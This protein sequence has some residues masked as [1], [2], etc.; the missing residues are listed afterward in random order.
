MML[1]W[2]VILEIKE[3]ILYFYF[4]CLGG[5]KI[6][7]KEKCPYSKGQSIWEQARLVLPV[8]ATNKRMLMV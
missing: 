7:P 8:R 1:I 4:L 2:S 3:T 5:K 6:C